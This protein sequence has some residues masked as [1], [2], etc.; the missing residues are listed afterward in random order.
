MITNPKIER[1]KADIA[2]TEAKLVEVRAR[3]KKQKE[4]LTK[5]EDDEIVAMFRSEIISE[6]DFAALLRSRRESESAN[7]DADPDS[8]SSNKKQGALPQERKEETPDAFSEN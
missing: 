1:K 6:D 2:R 3:I 5:L 7:D 8:D 4:E